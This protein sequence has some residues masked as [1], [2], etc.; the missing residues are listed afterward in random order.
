MLCEMPVVCISVCICEC[1]G[2]NECEANISKYVRLLQGY[3]TK[4]FN[5]ELKNPIQSNN[6][7]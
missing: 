5:T 7:I 3:E 4:D 6:I 2:E 1:M